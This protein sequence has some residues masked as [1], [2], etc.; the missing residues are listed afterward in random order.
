M[1]GKVEG[2]ESLSCEQQ[3]T[4]VFIRQLQVLHHILVS[5]C[6]LYQSGGGQWLRSLIFSF[7]PFTVIII[8]NTERFNS[9]IVA[10]CRY[11]WLLRRV[12]SREE[13]GILF[14]CLQFQVWDNYVNVKTN[15]SFKLKIKT[16]MKW[17]TY[18]E[19]CYVWGTWMNLT[20]LPHS[21]YFRSLIHITQK[22]TRLSKL[23]QYR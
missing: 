8:W 6:Q 16:K 19:L 22:S 2:V 4:S 18:C 3:W 14:I 13:A 15:I 1:A 12:G 21:S 11:C 5:L 23:S 20:P 7:I 10:A 9:V 17:R